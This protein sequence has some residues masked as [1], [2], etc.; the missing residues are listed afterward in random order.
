MD[1]PFKFYSCFLQEWTVHK[2]N[3]PH[4]SLINLLLFTPKRIVRRICA[5]PIICREDYDRII[6][7]TRRL[8]GFYYLLNTTVYGLGNVNDA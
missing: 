3:T 7:E 6:I 5:S 1:S 8:Q 2:A 4:P